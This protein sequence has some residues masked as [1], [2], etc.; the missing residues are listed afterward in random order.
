MRQWEIIFGSI[1]LG[2]K[3]TLGTLKSSIGM[4]S[5]LWRG[6]SLHMSLCVATRWQLRAGTKEAV[7]FLTKAAMEEFRSVEHHH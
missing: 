2:D 4:T 5:S 7:L 6:H 3:Q 1:R